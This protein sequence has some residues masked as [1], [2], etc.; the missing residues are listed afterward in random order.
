[1][2]I[3]KC[4]WKSIVI[5]KPEQEVIQEENQQADRDVLQ[6][7]IAELPGI[8]DPLSLNEFIELANEVIDNRDTDIFASVVERY[9]TE[10]E[11]IVEE[12]D[13]DDIEVE[14]VSTTEALKALEIV[15]L[16]EIQQENGE[17]T[18]LSALDRIERRIVQAKYESRKQTMITSFFK[19]R[20]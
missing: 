6:A 14:L 18:I 20:D 12:P 9:S 16:W 3:Q 19:P 8:T 1:L 15:K 5:K 2:S 10:K 7:Q 13:E 11:G 17:Q 4:F